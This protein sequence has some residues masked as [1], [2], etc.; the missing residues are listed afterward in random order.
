MNTLK[1]LLAGIMSEPEE[2][3]RWLVLADWLEENDDPRRGELV[4]LHRKLLATCCEPEKHPERV[5]WQTR[6]VVLIA[7]GVRPCVP[8]E[9]VSLPGDVEMTF[10]FVPPGSFLMG[11][12]NGGDDE[13]P[14]HTVKLTKSFY[15]GI[16]PVTQAQ[17]KTVMGI[18]PSEFKGADRPVECV[19]WDDCQAFCK[20]LTAT[21]RGRR[22]IRLPTEAQWEYA[23]R[24]GMTTEYSFGDRGKTG[25]FLGVGA[26]DCL[27]VAAWYGT[28]S[29]WV[30]HVVGQ[31]AANAWN[32]HDMYGN[33]CE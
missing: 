25:G 1:G 13:Q 15:L 22:E 24:A 2:E 30:T 23:C 9:T 12:N 20:K 11:S 17:W 7:E 27:G 31:L 16:Y 3:T 14:V 5:T 19:S 32:L 21:L 10:S 33:M 28:N 29:R 8:Q 6:I 18:E 26:T 4:R